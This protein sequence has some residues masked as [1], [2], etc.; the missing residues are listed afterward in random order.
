[1]NNDEKYMMMALDLAKKSLKTDDVPVGCVIVKNNKVIAKSFN[2]RNKK[3]NALC[4]AE[5]LAINKACKK[6]KDWYLKDC[7]MYVTLEPCI[8]CSG[9]II[10]SRISKVVYGAKSENNGCAGSVM[11]VFS[12]E[13][14]APHVKI[15]DGVLEKE[16]SEIL[17]KFFKDL[18]TKKYQK[19]YKN[20]IKK[21]K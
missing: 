8:M 18:R 3:N 2:T 4:H 7:V 11:D 17:V 6:L 20:K 9:A 1:M 14:M 19:L 13:K 10:Q 12:H 16:C 5:I 15:K 21:L